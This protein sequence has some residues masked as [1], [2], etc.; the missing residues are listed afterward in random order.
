MARNTKAE[1]IGSD[2]LRPTLV[3]CVYIDLM[4]R[5][6][7][8]IDRDTLESAISDWRAG[9]LTKTQIAKKYGIH[10]ETLKRR[11]AGIIQ[12]GIS[13][14]RALVAGALAGIP[15]AEIDGKVAAT[16]AKGAAL[17]TDAM[18]TADEVFRGVLKR[19]QSSVSDQGA[20]YSP[21]DL[22]DLVG[23]AKDAMEGVRRVRELDGPSAGDRP[24]IEVE[25]IRKAS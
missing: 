6:I 15:N 23:A 3:D 11:L 25:F 10:Y 13:T 16:V 4:A 18:V 21:K 12:D 9:V 22:K 24:K 2:Q 14:T 20:L 17:A 19:V 1:G 5:P 7:T 8:E